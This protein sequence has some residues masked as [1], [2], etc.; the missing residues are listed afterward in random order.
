MFLRSKY[1]RFKLYNLIM[2]ESY[3]DVGISFNSKKWV[4]INN[5]IFGIIL[6]IW[7]L[8]FFISLDFDFSGDAPFTDVLT[9]LIFVLPI[10]IYPILYFTSLYSRTLI[11]KEKYV[12]A[13]YVSL[14]PLISIISVLLLIF[15]LIIGSY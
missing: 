2:T 1:I 7:P 5:I 9:L 3:E 15:L 10:W 12:T 8:P 4:K 13:F 6:L 14:L 11:K